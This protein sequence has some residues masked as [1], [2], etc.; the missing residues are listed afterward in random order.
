MSARKR[1]LA[2]APATLARLSA[3]I[4]RAVSR[5]LQHAAHDVARHIVQLLQ[6]VGTAERRHRGALD[7]R[8]CRRHDVLNRQAGLE[9][10]AEL[11]AFAAWAM[12]RLTDVPVDLRAAA[13]IRGP[14]QVEVGKEGARIV[15]RLVGLGC[16]GFRRRIA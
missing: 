2:Q 8:A 16:G 9:R 6:A 5:L 1:Y 4:P 10:F 3:R 12:A 13:Q 11:A 7:A 14:L 15:L